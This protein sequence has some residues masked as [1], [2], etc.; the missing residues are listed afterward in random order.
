MA[1][2]IYINIMAMLIKYH[3]QLTGSHRQGTGL[4]ND[5]SCVFRC[6]FCRKDVVW[7]YIQRH[8]KWNI[9]IQALF[10]HPQCF[11]KLDWTLIVLLVN[12]FEL[13]RSW[14][15]I[16]RLATAIPGAHRIRNHYGV[17]TIEI[18]YTSYVYKISMVTTSKKSY[19]ACAF[20]C[21]IHF[22]YIS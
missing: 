20:H 21:D 15:K 17:T 10:R 4:K 16:W 9:G 1:D 7:L 2:C 8:N 19:Y 5:I 14:C 6:C 18:I 3:G 11:S 13:L 22:Q 12:K